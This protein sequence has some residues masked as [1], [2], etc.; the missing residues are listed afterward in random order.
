MLFGP[1]ESSELSAIV[2]PTEPSAPVLS[3]SAGSR[4]KPMRPASASPLRSTVTW[5][6]ATLIWPISVAPA[7]AANSAASISA[8][9]RSRVSESAVIFVSWRIDPS[10]RGDPGDLVALKADAGH[11]A[12]L[13][14][15]EGVD[16]IL[17]RRGRRVPR[18]ALVHDHHARTHAHLETI[19]LVQLREGVGIHEEHGI[20]EFLHPGLQP[21]GQ[22]R[23]AVVAHRL[24]VPEQRPLAILPADDEAGFLDA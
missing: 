6:F 13:A 12:P 22:S 24:A 8:A 7:N 5:P 10:V 20:S 11:Q 23:G 3:T 9:R 14:E 19:R 16:V 15:D 18:H 1:A 2:I 21:V 17:H 4:R